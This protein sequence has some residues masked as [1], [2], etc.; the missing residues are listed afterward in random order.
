MRIGRRFSCREAPFENLCAQIAPNSEDGALAWEGVPIEGD[1][2]AAGDTVT[3]D[4]G[5]VYEC[6]YEPLCGVAAPTNQL[7]GSLVWH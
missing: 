1:S 3:M 7:V 6:I 4:N 2:V 5:A